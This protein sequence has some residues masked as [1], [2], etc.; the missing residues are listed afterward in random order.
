[1]TGIDLIEDVY[2]ALKFM[3]QHRGLTVNLVSGDSTAAP[4]REEAGKNVDAAFES[5]QNNMKK[6]PNYTT[7][8]SEINTIYDHWKNVQS[9]STNSTAKEAFTLHSDLIVEILDFIRL[10][11][12]ETELSLDADS[13]KHHLHNLLIETLPPI[14][15]NMGKARAKGVGVATK[16]H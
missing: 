3:Q 4:K 10:I 5:L 2:P 16:K 11:A 6:Y 9:T 15:E 8:Q 1:M 13:I 14:T 12:L 7:I